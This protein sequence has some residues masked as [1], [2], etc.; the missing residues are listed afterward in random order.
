MEGYSPLATPK[1]S[2]M[3]E[4]EAAHIHPCAWYKLQ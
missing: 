4:P 1:K 3:T 2:D